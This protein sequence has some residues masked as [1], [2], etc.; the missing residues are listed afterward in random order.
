MSAR[1]VKLDVN[2]SGAWK[3][4]LIFDADNAGNNQTMLDAIG[5]IGRVAK[6]RFRIATADTQSTPLMY[7]SER[8]GWVM[9]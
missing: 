2:R 8:E 3:N 7:W 5:T 6:C 4:V 1:P 9:A